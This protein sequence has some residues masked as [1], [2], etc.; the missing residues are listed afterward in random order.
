MYYVSLECLWGFVVCGCVGCV[1]V[2]CVGLGVWVCGGVSV[3][4]WDGCFGG[5][6]VRIFLNI[7]ALT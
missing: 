5:G 4:D 2:L 1:G 7:K 3:C 6:C